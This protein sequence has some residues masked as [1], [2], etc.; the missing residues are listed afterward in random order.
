MKLFKSKPAIFVFIGLIFLFCTFYKGRKEE[1]RRAVMVQIALQALNT[2]HFQP[3]PINDVFSNKVFELYMKKID[4]NKIF[5]LQSDVDQLKKYQITIDDEIKNG[6]FKFL[7]L[8]TEMIEKRIREAEDFYKDILS[9]PFDFDKDESYEGNPKKMKYASTS[10]EMREFWRKYLKYQVL[11]RLE[12]SMQ[13]QEKARERKDTVIKVKTFA[14]MEE[15]ARSKVMK[16]QADLFKRLKDVD[17]NDRLSDYIN[18][19]ANSYDPHTEYFAP[20][21]KENFDITMTGQ[22][23][24]IGAQ[25]QEK[26]GYV[27]V[28]NIVPGSPSYRQGQLKAG[29]IIL[30]VAQGSQEAVDVTDMRIDNVVSLIRGK[31]GTEVR[32][33]V[34]KADGSILVIPIIRDIV[35]IEET[36]AHSAIIDNKQKIGYI[37]LP[38]F[39]APNKIGGRSSAEDVKKELIKLK[40]QN[41]KGLVLDLRDNGG[42][43]LQ[44]VV[45]MAGLFIEKGA[46]VQAKSKTGSPTLLEDNDGT[47]FYDGPLVVM[48]NSNSASAS[49]ILAAAIQDYK[50]GLVVGTKSTFGKGTVQR[51]FNLDEFINPLYNNMKPIG[52]IKIT[53]QK[54]YRVNGGATQLKGVIPDIVMPDPF[55][56]IET[57]EKDQEFPLQ[58]DVIQPVPITPWPHQINFEKIKKASRARI[59]ASNNFKLIND[60]AEKIRQQ[61]DKSAVSLNLKKFS[62]EQSRSKEEWKKYEALSKDIPEMNIS[63]L[64]EDGNPELAAD[65]VMQARNREFLKNLRKDIY[66]YEVTSV[67]NDF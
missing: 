59:E 55:T 45:E 10:K 37:R 8:S 27:K 26:D 18:S 52:S 32:L 44:D 50:R 40:S 62:E 16:S 3:Q 35:V 28:A 48:V 19:M 33:T 20:K 31:K 49:E 4:P 29:D 42:G 38:I 24:G 63:A 11:V 14:E 67:I 46:I 17:K 41:I 53:V 60:Q 66:L 54:F 36:Y 65:T 58:W 47:V 25:L 39:Y 12:E 5:L 2:A 34:K 23:E 13:I 21:D 51:F 22:L 61:R 64:R 9:Q 57:G 1:D 6:T 56:Y 30:K 7:E 15:E 43:S